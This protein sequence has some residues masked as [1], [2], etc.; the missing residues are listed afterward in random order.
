MRNFLW[1]EIKW[2][3][4]SSLVPSR[5]T[6]DLYVVWVIGEVSDCL[7][8]LE[9]HA[10]WGKSL[11][12]RFFIAVCFLETYGEISVFGVRCGVIYLSLCPWIKNCIEFKTI[13]LEENKVV[14]KKIYLI[15][16][17]KKNKM[18]FYSLKSNNQHQ[19]ALVGVRFQYKSVN[20]KSIFDV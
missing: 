7:G 19:L 16:F 9:L 1:R 18:F 10:N 3:H 14:L 5:T 15:S 17:T 13:K 2:C 4:P 20:K 8:L 11:M 12:E 6:G